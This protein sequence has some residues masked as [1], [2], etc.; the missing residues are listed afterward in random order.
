ME[1]ISFVYPASYLHNI[2]CCLLTTH[3]S[4]F[5]ERAGIF[6]FRSSRC[7]LIMHLDRRDFNIKER[8]SRDKGNLNER[9]I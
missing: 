5:R 6:K 9:K 4:Y 7:H 8:G 1:P 2:P 3:L